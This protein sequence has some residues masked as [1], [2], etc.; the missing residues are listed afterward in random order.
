MSASDARGR[1]V[2]V[3]TSVGDDAAARRLALALVGENLAACVSRSAVRSVYRW[4]D[5]LPV[6]PREMA[7]CEDEE[8]LLLVKTSASRLADVEKRILE[9]HPYACPE[10]VA[11]DADRV[12]G[13][14]L[15]WLLAC[16]E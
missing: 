4:E 1:A 9:L 6:P 13:R 10:V 14:Y 2:L 3:M 5:A 7:V 8:V 16:V 11:I 15:D 12:E